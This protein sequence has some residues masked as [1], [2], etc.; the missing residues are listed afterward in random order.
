M[1]YATGIKY[2]GN[3]KDV[4]F[5]KKKKNWKDVTWC[6]YASGIK[7]KVIREVFKKEVLLKLEV[8]IYLDV[9][10]AVFQN[11]PIN[12]AVAPFWRRQ[13]SFRKYGCAGRDCDHSAQAAWGKFRSDQRSLVNVSFRVHNFQQGPHR[14]YRI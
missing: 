10:Y 2:E 1:S 4:V 5:Q 12:S 7:W 3:R 8:S 13:A 6:F 11:W 14:F 9:A